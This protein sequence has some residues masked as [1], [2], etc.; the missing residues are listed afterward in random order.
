M[1]ASPAPDIYRRHSLLKRNRL[2]TRAE[3]SRHYE[4]FHGPLASNQPGFR[5]FATHYI[6]NHVEDPPDGGEPFFDGISITTQI[7][8]ADYST[9]FFTHPDYENV[10]SDEMYLLDITKTVSVL[11][12]EEIV[13]DG[14]KSPHKAIFITSRARMNHVALETLQHAVFNNLNTSS[15]SALGFGKSQF[16]HDLIAELW[17]ASAA[18]RETAYRSSLEKD[19]DGISLLIREVLFFSP[20]KPWPTA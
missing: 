10:K 2:H 1:V 11:G 8:R 19:P 3:F 17:F 9:G 12:R 13:V 16:S 7:P 14:T 5:K 18:D 4:T 6:Q 15:A 20:E